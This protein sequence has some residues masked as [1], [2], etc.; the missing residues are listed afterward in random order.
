MLP[1]KTDIFNAI[2]RII[3][4]TDRKDPPNRDYDDALRFISKMLSDQ[5]KNEKDISIWENIFG[6]LSSYIENRPGESSGHIKNI[7]RVSMDR[8]KDLLY[9]REISN[10]IKV[11]RAVI[12]TRAAMLGIDSSLTLGELNSKLIENITQFGINGCYLF[13]YDKIIRHRRTDTWIMPSKVNLLLA[14]DEKSGIKITSPG[15]YKVDTDKFI[16]DNLLDNGRRH[17]FLVAPNYF[18]F[19]QYGYIVYDMGIRDGNVYDFISLSISSTYRSILLLEERQSAEKRLREVLTER[20]EAYDKLQSLDR[21][22]TQFFSNISHE[23]RTPLTLM[24]APLDSIIHGSYG[25]DVPAGSPVFES[26]YRNGTRLLRLINQILDIARVEAGRIEVSK[27]LIDI[28]GFVR[29]MISSVESLAKIRNLSLSFFDETGG[30]NA[31]MDPD[32]MEKAVMNLLSNSLKFTNPGGSIMVGL[33]SEMEATPSGTFSIKVKDTGIGIEADKLD[34]IFERFYQAESRSN[35]KYEGSGIGLSL[36]KDIVELLDGSI[37]VKSKPGRGSTFSITLPIGGIDRENGIAPSKEESWEMHKY[38]VADIAGSG[39][40]PVGSETRTAPLPDKKKLPELLIVDDNA[41]MRL[42]LRENLGGVFSITEARNGLEG[43][44]RS[45]SSRPDIILA[46]VMMPEM[47]GLEMVSEIR[48]IEE[49]EGTPIILLTSRADQDNL[50]EGLELGAIDYVLKPFHVRELAA[51][52]NGQIEMKR[53]RDELQEKVAD[54]RLSEMR[55]REIAEFSASGIMEA[56][57]SFRAVYLNQTGQDLLELKPGDIGQKPP[58]SSFLDQSEHKRLTTYFE[59]L[60]DNPGGFP[61]FKMKRKGGDSFVALLKIVGISGAKEEAKF[62]IAFM[63]VNPVLGK[64]L[65]PGDAFFERYKLSSRE[66]EILLGILQDWSIKETSERLFIS[67]ATVKAHRQNIYNKIGI[68][69]T[70]E[71][72]DLIKQEIVD[73]CGYETLLFTILGEITGK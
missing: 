72:F 14:F 19:D 65:Q 48:K 9:G 6:E 50:I 49:L 24:L 68:S 46:D 55:Y 42:F 15:N 70:R 56:D 1:D 59:T 57:S 21:M 12:N 29:Q 31:Y 33:D 54:L 62:R 4:L 34:R 61:L 20:A 63:D 35:R 23:F 60:R 69:S 66:R 8:I 43:L 25:S 3:E 36:T 5:I 30:L 16:P 18:L 64:T 53:L 40:D 26:M 38:L 58:V 10:R 17:T 52:I 67:E 47:D 28:S 13:V 32:L 11:E 39:E 37:G 71:L 41:D 44:N 73:R 22:K 45:R 2:D 51:R 7:I 27:K